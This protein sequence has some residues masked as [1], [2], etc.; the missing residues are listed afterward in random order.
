MN[1]SQQICTLVSSVASSLY[2]S[3]D[4]FRS[5]ISRSV[6]SSF[7]LSFRLVRPSSPIDGIV[8]AQITS[9]PPIC[10]MARL[11]ALTADP[12]Q[13]SAALFDLFILGSE[14]RRDRIEVSFSYTGTRTSSAMGTNIS[15]KSLTTII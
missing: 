15:S 14:S 1:S 7:E 5:S 4:G 6:F 9:F 12:R 3:T 8:P 10:F 2:P 13:L 11:A